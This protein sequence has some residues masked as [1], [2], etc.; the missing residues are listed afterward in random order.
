M[1]D[2]GNGLDGGGSSLKTG[3][4]GLSW[5]TIMAAVLVVLLASGS[6]LWPKL[7]DRRQEHFFLVYDSS[8]EQARVAGV[9]ARL[10]E[11]LS[12]L[13]EEKLEVVV[14]TTTSEFRLQLASRPD[15]LWAPDGLAMQVSAAEFMPLV[16]GRRGAPYNLRPC[17]VLVY[18][19][20]VFG[21]SSAEAAKPWLKTP[22]ATVFGDSVSLVATTVLAQAN[23]ADW[24]KNIAVGP[25]SY[26][27]EPVLHALRLGGFDFAVVRQW[28]AERFFAAGL[29]DR[30]IYGL[31]KLSAPVPDGVLMASSEVPGPV[32]LQVAE[33]LSVLGRRQEAEGRQSRELRESLRALRLDGFNVIMAPD[34]DLERKNHRRNWLPDAQ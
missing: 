19:R 26:N 29:L 24:P 9:F 34:W 20:S 8:G 1:T 22:A 5:L 33:A 14:A 27:H 10:G 16:V 18:R 31:Q 7:K 4:A 13:S 3:R 23:G 17:S 30:R 28:D 11:Y 6:L 12:W 25:D 21:E 32:R 2:A 15:F